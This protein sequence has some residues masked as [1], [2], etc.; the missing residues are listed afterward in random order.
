MNFIWSRRINITNKSTWGEK[1]SELFWAAHISTAGWI[2]A[3]LS[4]GGRFKWKQQWLVWFMGFYMVGLLGFCLFVLCK[5]NFK[6]I[7]EGINE[8]L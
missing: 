6:E 3:F 7:F 4:M 2:A 1:G 5:Q 8:D